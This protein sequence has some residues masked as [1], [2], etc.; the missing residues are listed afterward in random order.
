MAKLTLIAAPTFKAKVGIPLHGGGEGEVEFTF[1]HRT[2][3]D[4]TAW[5]D[6]AS[7]KRPAEMILDMVEGW[8][9]EE[10][11]SPESVATFVENYQGAAIPILGKYTQ[12]LTQAR[13]GN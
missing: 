5:L 4:L 7:E 13:L 1:K 6:V 3:S 10:P 9:L 8:D 2:K 12:E 11:F